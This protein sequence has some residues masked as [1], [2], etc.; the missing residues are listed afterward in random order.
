MSVARLVTCQTETSAQGPLRQI[1][2]RVKSIEVLIVFGIDM[3]FLKQYFS[4]I[5][6]VQLLAKMTRF[7]RFLMRKFYFPSK[8]K[9]PPPKIDFRPA[10]GSFLLFYFTIFS[11][12]FTVDF[13]E[14]VFT[15]EVLSYK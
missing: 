7:W 15:C 5:E 9:L 6:L 4:K 10:F 14:P 11:T 1:L 12:D 2:V 13:F 3:R 8:M